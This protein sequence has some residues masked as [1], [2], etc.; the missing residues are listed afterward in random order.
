M[1]GVAGLHNDASCVIDGGL[2]RNNNS[3][4]VAVY[5]GS[6]LTMRSGTISENQADIGAGVYVVDDG[7][8]TMS[9]GT[10]TG[11]KATGYGGG[12]YIFDR[13]NFEQTGGS[14]RGNTA[15]QGSDPDMA[16][17]QWTWSFGR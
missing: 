9:G 8:F 17:E 12:L 13:N 11:N 3:H 7:H 6:V 15:G 5:K 16:A 4:G 2:I 10:I 14:I 1:D